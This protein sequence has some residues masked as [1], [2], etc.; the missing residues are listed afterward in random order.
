[1]TRIIFCEDDPTIQKLI[2]IALR[3]EPYEVIITDNG[4]DGLVHIK[5][6]SPCII[7][8]DISM[9]VMDG[10]QLCDLL[11]LDATLKHIPIVFLTASIQRE[12]LAE[13]LSHGAVSYLSKPFSPQELR[14]IIKELI[15]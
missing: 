1:M 8:T 14:A 11:Q 9:P 12:E 13:A 10:V 5:N 15:V 2:R 6:Q 3:N 4:Q 7:F